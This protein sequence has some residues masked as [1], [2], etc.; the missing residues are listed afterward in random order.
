MVMIQQTEADRERQLLSI[1]FSVDFRRI[2]AFCPARTRES[3]SYSLRAHRIK[4]RCHAAAQ[5]FYGA[6]FATRGLTYSAGPN[7]NSRF[8]IPRYSHARWIASAIAA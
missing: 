8:E 3:I 7:F 5:Y 1:K 4:I 2:K 6:V